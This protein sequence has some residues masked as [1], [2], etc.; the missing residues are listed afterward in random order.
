[1]NIQRSYAGTRADQQQVVAL[2]RQGR[3][4]AVLVP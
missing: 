1:V 2:A 3:L 4:H